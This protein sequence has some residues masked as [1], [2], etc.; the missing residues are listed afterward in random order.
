MLVYG[1]CSE[2]KKQTS[3]SHWI[4]L[5]NGKKTPK[6]LIT[7][8]WILHAI[9]VL[10]L[11]TAIFFFYQ[12]IIYLPPEIIITHTTDYQNLI[13][14]SFGLGGWRLKWTSTDGWPRRAQVKRH[15]FTNKFGI[16]YVYTFGMDSE[17]NKDTKDMADTLI[18]FFCTSLQRNLTIH[19]LKLNN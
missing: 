4:V 13:F 3:N 17:L 19:C 6:Q 15:R 9:N 8:F 11:I 12:I 18:D 14:P 10:N 7:S 5:L 1:D 2:N 16:G